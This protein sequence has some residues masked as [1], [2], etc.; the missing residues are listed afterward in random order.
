MEFQNPNTSDDALEVP[1]DGQSEDVNA[2]LPV[3]D[4][5]VQLQEETL[6]I[7]E[8]VGEIDD[9]DVPS[10]AEDE[11]EG[12]EGEEEPEDETARIKRGQ[13]VEGK[14]LETSPTEVKVDLGEG[15]VGLVTSR[16][17][18]R[19]DRA[20]IEEL[21]PGH[22]LLVYVLRSSSQSG[23]PILS[24]NRA[25]EEKDWLDAKHNADDK[26][27][28]LGRVAGYNKG[29]LIIRFGCLRGFV[30]ASQISPERDQH[31][32][33]E[34]P[35][36]RFGNLL[37]QEIMVKVVEVNRSRNRLI[38]SERAATREW[39][40][41]RKEKLIRELKV[42]EIRR[43]QVISLTDFGAFVDLGG[44]DGL[45]HLT[46]MSWKHVSHPREVL[47][48]GQE[49]E[50]KVISIDP[51]RKRIGLSSKVLE[52]DPWD[53][54]YRSY[55]VDQLVQGKITK[56]TRFGAFASLVDNSD[57]EGLIHVSE[58]AD[59]RVEH[60]RDVVAVGDVLTLRVVKIDPERRRLGL[61]LK[62][63]DSPK[64]MSSDWGNVTLDEE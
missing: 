60:P 41:H 64:Y 40:E 35:D 45:L 36:E 44:A 13:L 42:G 53:E 7:E 58:L 47:Q 20:S 55:K 32:N 3:Q 26:A 39:R 37:N 1:T 8:G 29:G 48:V 38:L 57:I 49:I 6:S 12:E 59:Y 63:V 46:E 30:P 43:G 23:Y 27:T 61:S 4:S 31:S 54:V 11:I 16:E 21:K 15:L 10:A 24:I 28:F 5:E 9:S 56:L 50:V 34:N 2:E 19:L 22:D 62:R 51:D 33:A 17:L 18:D 25:R 14:I 52:N